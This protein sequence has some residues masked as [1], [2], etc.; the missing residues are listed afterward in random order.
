MSVYRKILLIILAAGLL[1]ALLLALLSTTVLLKRVEAA[2]SAWVAD[3]VHFAE[4]YLAGELAAMERQMSDWAAWDDA[5]AF[6]VKRD[7][8]FIASSYTLPTF[9]NNRWD[10]I[11]FLDKAGGVAAGMKTSLDRKA[12]VPVSGEEAELCRRVQARLKPDATR[13]GV[14]GWMSIGGQPCFIS[15]HNIITSDYTGP[16]RGAM[17]GW[18]VLSPAEVARMRQVSHLDLSLVPAADAPPVDPASRVGVQALDSQRILGLRFYEDVFGKPL[19]VAQVALHRDMR[20][21]FID[22]LAWFLASFVLGMLAIGLLTMALLQRLVLRRLSALHDHLAQVEKSRE[23]NRR[24]PETGN[25][26]VSRLS[27][28]T[29]RLLQALQE[30][31]EARVR[32]MDE[33]RRMD[34]QVRRMQKFENLGVLAGGIA[35][36]F[37]N[38]LA[39]LFSYL[40]VGRLALERGELERARA[41]LDKGVAVGRRATDLTQQ[42]LTFSKGG[43]PLKRVADL[44]GLLKREVDFSLSG[45]G[46]RARL[47]LDP[48]LWLCSMDESQVA[49]VIDNLVINARQAMPG[50][51]TL[52]VEAGNLAPGRPLPLSLA[53]GP[54]VWASFTDQGPG[55]PEGVLA[56]VFDPFFTTKAGGTGLGL[57]IAFSVLERHGGAITASNSPQG[58]AVFTFY[59]PAM[60]GATRAEIKDEARAVPLAGGTARIL[61]MDDEADVRD[62]LVMTLEALGYQA[63][64][65]PDGR[66]AV[67]AWMRGQEQGQPF[68]AVIMDLTIPGGMGGREAMAR[69]LELDPAVR[70]IVSSGYTEEGVLQ[71]IRGHGFMASLQKPYEIAQLR[72]TLRSVLGI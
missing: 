29:N 59:L 42:L 23:L 35:H 22:T 12:L 26:E 44:A 46:V 56:H 51:G 72:E 49:Q 65:V 11:V 5:Y 9:I 32:L 41:C 50:A 67:E 16:S 38:L 43:A 71:D 53:E 60:P 24:V 25:D 45:S 18:R 70:G 6:M 34:E 37:N 14:N 47:A 36:D 10:A 69:L 8:K 28:A 7:P 39:G 63:L 30:D 48:D 61:V 19:L 33:R 20:A 15:A 55:I 1:L 4:D 13:E 31:M 27:M 57:A 21:N 62:S 40:E 66:A 54:Y 52:Q 64:G 2:E 58:G 17:V 68:Q 3:K